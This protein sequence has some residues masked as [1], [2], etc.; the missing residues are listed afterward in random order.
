MSR[1]LLAAARGGGGY[2]PP[3]SSALVASGP[4][5][6][7]LTVSEA[8]LTQ[9]H[10]HTNQSDGSFSPAAVVA[11]YL[12]AGYGALSLTDHDKVTSQPAGITTAIPGNELSPT[13]QHII[14]INTTYVRGA[15]TDAQAII[16][17]VVAD[18]GYAEIAHPKWLRGMTYDEM[19]TLTDYAGLE[20]HNAK[21]V[22]GSGQNPVT[23]PGYALD[24]W[25]QLLAGRRDLWAFAVDDL[26]QIDAYNTYDIGRL[27]VFVQTNNVAGVAGRIASGNFVADVSNHGVAPGFP[28][29]TNSGVSVSCAGATRIEAWGPSG[30]LG[31]ASGTSLSYAYGSE[32]YV[33][34]VAVGDYTEAFGAALGHHWQSQ[35]GT[36]SVGSGVLSLASDGNAHNIIL[37]RH[38]EGDFTA[39]VDVMLADNRSNEGALFLFNVLTSGYY[40]G[41]RL[42]VSSTSGENDKLALRKVT[43]G[44]SSVLGNTTYIATE[45]VWHRVKLAYT[46]AT[47]TVQAKVWPVGD[48][49]PDWML[50]HSDTAW[51][52][53]AFALRAN[54]TAQ[55][56]NLYIDGFRTYYQPIALD[57][58]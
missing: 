4:Y 28:T 43:N 36:W 54:Y 47:G 13:A 53:G 55:F 24:R 17:G 38:R 6:S 7:A 42:G 48:A 29:R 44:T 50:T 15:E 41:L 5:S 8:V 32:P 45:D 19:V 57:A 23:Y 27:Q 30:I 31:S 9:V 40:Y 22:G 51:R 10:C 2:H 52:N 25:D 34:L 33:R 16:D 26:H 14:G 11:D 56:D 35:S 37:R 49:E 1:R 39:T 21:V 3:P 46:S 18:G 20:I 12:S 58:A